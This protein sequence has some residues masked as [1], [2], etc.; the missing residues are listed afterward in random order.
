MCI[1]FDDIDSNI[2]ALLRP[3]LEIEVQTRIGHGEIKSLLK[4]FSKSN[5]VRISHWI[6]IA[7]T[8]LM[9][10]DGKLMKGHFVHTSLI[11]GLTKFEVQRA[12]E[13]LNK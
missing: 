8:N 11:H 4:S 13:I 6:A 1:D 5:S 2:F 10:W 9:K 12:I 7:D 3:F